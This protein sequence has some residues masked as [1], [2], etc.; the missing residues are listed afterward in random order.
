MDMKQMMDRYAFTLARVGLKVQKGQTV[1]VEAALDGAYFVP[2]FAK[3]CY[4][5]GAGNV[6]VHYLDEA[7]LKV[8]AM[9]RPLSEVEK[10][11]EWEVLS[12]QKYRQAK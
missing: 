6:V 2:V 11:E 12:N 1:L 4:E 10:I 7:M 8:S 3:A 9:H 5:A